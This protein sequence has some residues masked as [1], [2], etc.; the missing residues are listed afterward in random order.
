MVSPR[1]VFSLWR[2]TVLLELDLRSE[3]DDEGGWNSKISGRPLRIVRED[4]EQNLSPKRHSGLIRGE[5]RL[6][7]SKI[8]DVFEVD[9]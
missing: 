5:N 2:T 9:L 6:A 4:A 1:A 7:S 8:S 3:F